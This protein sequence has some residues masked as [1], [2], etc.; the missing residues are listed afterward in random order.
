VIGPDEYHETI[1]DNAFT[2]VMARA[3]IGSALTAA[4]LLRERWPAEWDRLAAHLTLS[5][6]ELATWQVA[7]DTMADGLDPQTGLFEQFAGFATLER[8]DL[9]AYAGRSVPM[10][11]ILGRARIAKSQVIK[12]ADVVAL[13]GLRPEEFP[14]KTGAANYRYYEPRCSHGSSLS[15]AMHGLVAARL[16]LTD[17]ALR[18][19]QQTAAIDLGDTQAA[20]DGGLHVAALGGLWQTAVLGFAG[21]SLRPDGLGLD[22]QLP[23]GWRSFG[24]PI[25]W[26][27][28]RLHIR[29]DQTASVVDA[30]LETGDPMVLTIGGTA[31]GLSREKPLQ[32]DLA[33]LPARAA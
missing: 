24:F 3:N 15:R 27:G 7:A 31:H 10:D 5:D 29:I 26:H 18:Y 30:S 16:G 8:I 33:G 32:V 25:A 6:A 17:L 22:P 19:F 12:Q 9:A 21:L 4:A 11:V 28:R 13:L 23:A 20:T 2:N 14:G 1:D